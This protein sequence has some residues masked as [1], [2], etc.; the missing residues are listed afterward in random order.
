MNWTDRPEF[1][2]I[3]LNDS[4]VLAWELN[5][6]RLAFDLEASIW[7]ESPHY[8]RPKPNEHT[9]YRRAQLIFEGFISVNGLK[10]MDQVEGH[11]DP[12]GTMDF[13]CI[14]ELDETE[15]GFRITGEFGSVA[16]SGGTMDF[17]ICGAK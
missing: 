5:S 15:S 9:C 13:D 7:P 11:I 12:D 4:F 2:G 1:R 3:D 14:E 8:E 16:I 17:V 10:N 6:D